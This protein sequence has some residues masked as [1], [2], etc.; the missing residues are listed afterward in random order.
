MRKWLLPQR[1]LQLGSLVRPEPCACSPRLLHATYA[2]RGAL[3]CD[4]QTTIVVNREDNETVREW[5]DP[6]LGKQSSL[7]G[8][9]LFAL[10]DELDRGDNFDRSLVNLGG[11][12]QDL[13]FR[14]QQTL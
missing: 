12:V 7:R 4:S 13:N 10:L 9:D 5:P 8:T 2:P 1:I 11:N 3:L 14:Q 6:K